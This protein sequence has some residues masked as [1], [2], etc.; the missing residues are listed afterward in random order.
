MIMERGGNLK[1]KGKQCAN[2]RIWE[3]ENEK[4]MK[5]AGLSPGSQPLSLLLATAKYYGLRKF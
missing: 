1:D 5:K 4:G 2:L 3:F